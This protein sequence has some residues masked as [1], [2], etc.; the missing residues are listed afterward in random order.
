MVIKNP[1]DPIQVDTLKVLIYGQPGVRKTSFAF[2]AKRTLLLDFDKGVKRVNPKYRGNYTVI[3][4]WTDTLGLF[5]ID[6]SQY[7]TIAIDTVGKA[8][9]LL[10][11]QIMKED[12][13]LRKKDGSLSLQ[14][15]G[16]L[17]NRFRDFMNRIT[18]LGKTVV[19]IAHDKEAKQ[20]DDTIIRPDITGSSLSNIIREV[21]LCG[22]LRAH[23]NKAVITFNPSDNFYGKNTC[24]LPDNLDLDQYN[25]ADIIEQALKNMNEETEEYRAYKEQ[26]EE[27]KEILSKCKN[28][29]HLNAAK[30]RFLKM[31]FISDGKIQAAHL[32]RDRANELGCV[33]NSD[34]KLY[35]N[36]K[37]Q[38]DTPA[39]E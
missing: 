11:V 19:L 37:V 3:N 21:D 36:A 9:D 23:N 16:A 35:E 22:Y 32:M 24:G 29:K 4:E 18:D 28:A 14:G 27:V 17:S 8:L 39:A 26:I 38:S 6:L 1:T 12:F 33:I 31:N 2:T 5:K 15:F 10:S 7:D 34:T 30:E 13:K 25:L 20:G